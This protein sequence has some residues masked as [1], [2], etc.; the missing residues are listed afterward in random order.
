MYDFVISSITANK[1]TII[2]Q[3]VMH[4]AICEVQSKATEVQKE[5]K[6]LEADKREIRY[7]NKVIKQQL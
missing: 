4:K 2:I 1:H 7:E 3:K 6:A 5:L